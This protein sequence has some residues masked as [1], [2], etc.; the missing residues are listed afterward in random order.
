MKVSRFVFNMF[1]VNTYVLWDPA[2][3]EVIIV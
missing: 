2:S 1:G 3:H